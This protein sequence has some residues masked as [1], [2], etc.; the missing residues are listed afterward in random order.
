MTRL[1]DDAA[2][3]LRRAAERVQYI[4]TTDPDGLAWSWDTSAR[5]AVLAPA[6]AAAVLALIDAVDRA[7]FD[8]GDVWT[9]LLRVL[10]PAADLL[11]DDE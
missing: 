4:A 3:R 8:A 1:T 2:A 5:V 10:G 7:E 6:L 11:P 9:P